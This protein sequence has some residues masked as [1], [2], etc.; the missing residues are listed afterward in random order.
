MFLDLSLVVSRPVGTCELALICRA[1]V[2]TAV[3]QV[4]QVCNV[5]FSPEVFN[6]SQV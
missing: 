6:I 4:F 3:G 5:L 1:D 2:A